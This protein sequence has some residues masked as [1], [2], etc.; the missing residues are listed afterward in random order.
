VIVDF[1]SL[2]TEAASEAQRRDMDA[3]MPTMVQRAELAMFREL[4][5]SQLDTTFTGTTSGDTIPIPGGSSIIERVS[6]S[7]NGRDVTLDFTPMAGADLYT[8]SPGLPAFY[9]Q[10]NGAIRIL[11][12]P[13][14]PYSY[15]V[16]YAPNLLPLSVSNTQN[17]LLINHSD[18]YLHQVCVQIGMYSEDDGLIQRHT[19]FY[20][21]FRD[22]V[23][24][25]D[26]RKRLAR[27]GGLQM[28]PR[29]FR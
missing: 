2:M 28:R 6:L 12:A 25:Q 15:T 26:G 14:G 9:T 22:A 18:M 1:A 27:R 21:T 4:E 24:S 16:H 11:P 8:T 7:L 20:N 3:L 13:A 19:Q 17:W 23:I 29:S 5:L 10:E